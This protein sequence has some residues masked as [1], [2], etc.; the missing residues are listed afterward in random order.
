MSNHLFLHYKIVNRDSG[1]CG[2]VK[3]GASIDEIDVVRA[4]A[5]RDLGITAEDDEVAR[6]LVRKAING[7]NGSPSRK[8]VIEYEP[9]HERGYLS[10][11]DML[12][13][14][15]CDYLIVL[16]DGNYI[17][18]MSGDEW[19]NKERMHVSGLDY[20]YDGNDYLFFI[21]GEKSH[22][23]GFYDSP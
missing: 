10:I 1:I 23:M 11:V 13:G 9:K 19:E 4:C 8:L 21:R 18:H 15:L 3:Q 2:L 20:K 5:R 16:P 7:M 12:T 14:F 17:I 22:V 6:Q